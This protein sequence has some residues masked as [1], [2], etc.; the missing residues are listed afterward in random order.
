MVSVPR[1]SIKG[2]GLKC[3]GWSGCSLA[4]IS[5]TAS[6][7][8]RCASWASWR[9]RGTTASTSSAR[10]RRGRRRVVHLLPRPAALAGGAV[11]VAI[12]IERAIKKSA[13]FC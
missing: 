6:R 12:E 11:G 5:Q 9:R 7:R 2:Y 3:P 4:A 13:S 1:H 10:A 8:R